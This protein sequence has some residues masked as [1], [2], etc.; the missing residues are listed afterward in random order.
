MLWSSQEFGWAEIDDAYATG[1]SI[2]PQKKNP[3]VAELARGKA[4]RLIGGLTGLLVTLKGLPLTY[5]RD[6]QEDK[7]P[8]FDAVD[9]LLLV[10]PAM[11]GLVVHAADPRRAAGGQR[12]GRASRWPPTWPSCWCGAACRSARRTRSSGTWWCGARCTTWTWPRSSDADLAHVSPHLT[13]DVREVLSVGRG[14]RRA[15][16]R[17]AG[18]RRSGWPSSSPRCARRWTRTP[19]GR[20]ELALCVGRRPPRE[21]RAQGPPAPGAAAAAAFFARP[22][23]EVAPR[24]LGCVLATSLRRRAWSR[25]GSPRSRRTRARRIRRRTP[26]A[27]A[28]RRNAVMFGAARARV[29]VLHLRHALL[30]EPGLPAGGHGVG[31]AAAGGAVVAGLRW[32][33]S[34]GRPGGGGGT[35]GGRA[36][37]GGWPGAALADRDLARGPARLCQALGIDRALD[38]A[39]VCDPASPL[40]ISARPPAAPSRPIRAR[41]RGSG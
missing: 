3:D 17:A 8:V 27:G 1:S 16:L 6:L 35:A 22:A 26:T 32:P 28:T 14:D 20:A 23:L 15:E 31:G 12:D 11:A 5:N 39:D 25:C 40:R 36:G 37:R 4:G 21:R 33:G 18:P 38:G 13:P 19:P 7:E 2:M 41:A 30:R 34:A 24:L 9:T 29:R 10:L